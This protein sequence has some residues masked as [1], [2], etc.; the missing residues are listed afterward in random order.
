RSPRE[1]WKRLFAADDSGSGSN[2][3]LYEITL[4]NGQKFQVIPNGSNYLIWGITIK[5]PSRTTNSHGDPVSP[6]FAARQAPP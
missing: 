2:V 3:T 4:H 6:F 1:Q 5:T